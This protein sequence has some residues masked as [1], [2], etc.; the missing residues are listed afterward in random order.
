LLI[1]PVG[2]SSNPTANIF[3]P[4]F[5]LEGNGSKY[6]IELLGT[7]QPSPV[8]KPRHPSGKV[9]DSNG[10]VMKAKIQQTL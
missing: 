4:N 3:R 6:H 10:G 1:P 7:Q 9:A 5:D 2:D 8:L